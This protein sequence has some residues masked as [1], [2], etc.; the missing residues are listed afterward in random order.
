[1]LSTMPA[2]LPLP[3]PAAIRLSLFADQPVKAVVSPALSKPGDEPERI[4]K[5]VSTLRADPEPL[6]H[7]NLGPRVETIAV[8]LESNEAFA[9][10]ARAREP[11][12]AATP[13][14]LTASNLNMSPSPLAMMG[15]D[16]SNRSILA[17]LEVEGRD[18]FRGLTSRMEPKFDLAL[19]HSGEIVIDAPRTSVSPHEIRL[20]TLVERGLPVDGLGQPEVFLGQEVV[21]P[22][23]MPPGRDD[24]ALTPAALTPEVIVAVPSLEA[25]EGRPRTDRE[26]AHA[27]DDVSIPAPEES[28]LLTG[29]LPMGAAVIDEAIDRVLGQLESLGDVVPGTH[30]PVGRVVG[31]LALTSAMLALDVAIRRRRA[32]GRSAETSAQGDLGI[33][34]FPG[35]PGLRNRAL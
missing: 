9:L 17:H 14:S 35:L 25:T 30:P 19:Q 4:A 16:E 28:G 12:E 18:E 11:I 32:R 26:A 3:A 22:S 2:S 23:I 31:T 21:S 20:P 13:H 5:M 10:K 7:P 27:Y 6:N 15:E 29:F 24:H 1:M 34:H 8:N 33:V